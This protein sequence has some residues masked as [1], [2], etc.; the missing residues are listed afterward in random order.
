V[1]GV[2]DILWSMDWVVLAPIFQHHA[3]IR[4]ADDG[5][6]MCDLN[7]QGKPD[8]LKYLGLLGWPLLVNGV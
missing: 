5:E 2:Q 7:V 4:F 1:D 6:L 3:K 8:P